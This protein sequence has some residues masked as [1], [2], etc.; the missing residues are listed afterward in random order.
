MSK[1][2][3]NIIALFIIGIVGGIFADQILWPYFIERPLFYQYR[4]EQNPVHITENK[5]IIIQENTAFQEAV[6]RVQ[7][8]IVG[9]QTKTSKGWILQGSG[10]VLTTDGLILTLA[11]LLPAYSQSSFFVEGQEFTDKVLKKDLKSNLALVKIE[12][13]DLKTIGFADSVKLGQRVFLLGVVFNKGVPVIAVNEGII[14][15]INNNY[16]ETNIIEDV[17]FAGAALFDIEGRLVGVSAFDLKGHLKII[18]IKK[19]KDFTG[20]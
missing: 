4:L 14:K 8:S 11:E 13:L 5:E 1:K 15:M 17:S 18:P 7:K 10:V 12:A 20:L 9:V 2:I 16:L 19:I 3:L 6:Q